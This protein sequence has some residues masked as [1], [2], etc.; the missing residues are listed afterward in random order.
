MEE[1]EKL[2]TDKT[3]IVAITQMS[4]AIGTI[5]PVKEVIAKA[6]AVVGEGAGGRQPERGAY[7]D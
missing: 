5:V 3:K 7:A 4:N 1:F 6:H 2:L